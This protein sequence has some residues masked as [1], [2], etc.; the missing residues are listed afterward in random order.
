MPANLGSI[1]YQHPNFGIFSG[2][3]VCPRDAN[4]VNEAFLR[5][6]SG[7]QR[8]TSAFLTPNDDLVHPIAILGSVQNLFCEIDKY[9]RVAQSQYNLGRTSI[10]QTLK[11]AGPLP[12]PEFPPKWIL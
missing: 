7:Q 6:L 3:R 10:K 12:S 8:G 11:P 1:E 5:Q 9:A 2:S 4:A